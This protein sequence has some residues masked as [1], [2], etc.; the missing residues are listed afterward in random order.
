MSLFDI[1]EGTD[2]IEIRKK[3]NKMISEARKN[4]KPEKCI[5]CGRKQSSFCNSHSVPQ[6]SL[7]PIADKGKVLHASM[8]MGFDI[9]IVDLEGGVNNSGTFNYIC[10]ECDGKFFQDYENPDNIRQEPTDKMLAEI[11]VK[12]ML[13]QLNKRAIERELVSVQQRELGMYENPDDLSEIKNL[14]QKEYQAE[15]LFHQDIVKNNITGGYQIL[16]WKVLPYKVP[17]AAQSAIVLPYDMEG[18]ALNDIY[19]LDE[20]VRMQ[21]VHIA[22]LPLEGESVV[23]AFYHKRDKLYRQLRHQINSSSQEK[24]LQYIN[25]LIFEHT[26]NIYFSKK[27]EEEIKNN[28]MIEKLSQEANGLPRFGHLS[29]DNM[30]GMGYEAVKPED[31]PNFLDESWAIKEEENTDGEE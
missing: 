11:A 23:L 12:N 22:V 2:I 9:G 1:P 15:V 27:I 7:R 6:M 14:D 25:Y 19:N 28:K 5:L 26:E 17:I 20:S 16:F 10:R 29:A 18:N 3:V 8:A 24:V 4:A 30:F 31:I 21:Y 13:L